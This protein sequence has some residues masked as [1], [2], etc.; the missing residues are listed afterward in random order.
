MD[1]VFVCRRERDCEPVSQLGDPFL[2][3]GA[4]KPTGPQVIFETT[5]EEVLIFATLQPPTTPSSPSFLPSNSSL[6]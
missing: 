3:S 6:C 2:R 1:A 5:E 4:I